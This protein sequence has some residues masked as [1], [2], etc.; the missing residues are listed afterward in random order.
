MD[1]QYH[2]DLSQFSLDQL[3]HVLEAGSLLPSEQV[4]GEDMAGCFERLAS[5]GIANLQDLVDRLG[6]KKKLIQF[7]EASGLPEKHLTVLRRRAGT[8]AS[9]P[10]PL[11]KFPGIDPQVVERLAALGIKHS[12]H[13][14]DRTQSRDDRAALA[15]KAGVPEDALLELVKLSDLVRA[16]Y[17]GP[18][19]ARILYEAGADTL[20]KL[21]ACEG[22]GLKARMAAVNEEQQITKASIPQEDLNPWLET[23]RLIPQVIEY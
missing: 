9:K 11:A 14:F 19:Y 17:V 23:V 13:L 22:E 2:M 10:V 8:Y 18:V 4:L 15:A 1:S 16:A 7:S 6:S 20:A 21:A 3:R 12:K 5:L